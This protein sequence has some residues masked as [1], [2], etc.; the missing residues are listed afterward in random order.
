MFII[1]QNAVNSLFFADS[2]FFKDKY[3]KKKKKSK[4][5]FSLN[6]ITEYYLDNCIKP[7]GLENGKIPDESLTDDNGHNN[8]KYGRLNM[9]DTPSEGGWKGKNEILDDWFQIDLGSLFKVNPYT[10]TYRYV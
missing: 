9:V 2:T 1:V 4:W 5:L 8:A 7:L 10:Y 3:F 6:F